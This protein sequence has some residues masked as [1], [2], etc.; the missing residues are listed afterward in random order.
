MK[1]V[2]ENSQQTR[3]L[4]RHSSYVH[5]QRNTEI[6]Y[7]KFRNGVVLP[8]YSLPSLSPSLPFLPF[9]TPQVPVPP[10]NPAVETGD[11][12]SSAF[13]R[14]S[15]YFPL[16]VGPLNTARG[17]RELCKFPKRVWGRAPAKIEFGAF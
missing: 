6:A 4:V 7:V 2:T 16:E 3:I 15:V 14:I 13:R 1:E 8:S 17:L 9:P 10:L 12:H 11:Q 5:E